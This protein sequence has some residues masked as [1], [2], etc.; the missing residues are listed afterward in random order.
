MQ[1]E[2]VR[3]L[4]DFSKEN[5]DIRW[6]Y[7]RRAA[8]PHGCMVVSLSMDVDMEDSVKAILEFILP[9]DEWAHRRALDGVKYHHALT[10][11]NEHLRS[12]IKH[13]DLT[14]AAREELEDV[15]KLL[16]E[17]VPDLLEDN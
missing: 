2:T 11:I 17:E 14:K 8:P 16:F 4:E 3:R 12:R 13:A 5:D 15:R 6:N 10:T 1:S 9:D 7:R